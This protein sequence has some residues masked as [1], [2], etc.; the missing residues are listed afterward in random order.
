MDT[1]MKSSTD[2]WFVAY[3]MSQGFT[4]QEYRVI[5]RG[6][7]EC[8]FEISEQEW[9]QQKLAFNHSEL[10]KF[11]GLIEQVKDLAF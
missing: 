11:K 4:V 10:I 2:I 1:I 6:K 8:F 3:L 5:S 7:V 9:K